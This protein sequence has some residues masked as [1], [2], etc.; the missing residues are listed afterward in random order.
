ME[1]PGILTRVPSRR[2][3]YKRVGG[4]LKPLVQLSF[5][6]AEMKAVDMKAKLSS[7]GK[8]LPLRCDAAMILVLLQA[9]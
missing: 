4:N 1:D 2:E 8:Y 9:S 5:D 6:T 3:P 7:S